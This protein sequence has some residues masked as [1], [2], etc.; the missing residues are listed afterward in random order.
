[1]AL[2]EVVVMPSFA[3]PEMLALALQRISEADS[4]PVDVRIYQDTS[5][6]DRLKE[7]IF[8][9]DKYLPRAVIYHLEPHVEVISGCYNILKSI[10]AGYDFGSDLIWLIEEDVMVKPRFFN[11]G[12]EQIVTGQYLAA[13]GRK[14]RRFYN[15]YPDLYTNPGSLLS[16][17][18]VEQLISHINSDYFSRLRG[19]LDEKLPPNWDEQSHLDDG[20]V[21]RVIRQMGG[22][23]VYPETPVCAHQ[24]FRAYNKLD[25]YMNYAESIEGK[26]E[27]LREILRTVKP[28]DRYT[29]DFDLF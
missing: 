2:K 8:V 15:L 27:R 4:P 16:R 26:I 11:W 7:V 1:M 19:Y 6:E 23:V 25:L 13:C 18:L 12:R 22:K 5:T 17:R 29:G 28:T 20:L 10:Q 14:D 21:R 3:R 9:R 24:G